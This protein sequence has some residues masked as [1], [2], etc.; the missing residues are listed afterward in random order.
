M[1]TTYSSNIL[2]CE[3]EKG[4]K[5]PKTPKDLYESHNGLKTNGKTITIL[6]THYD[7]HSDIDKVTYMYFQ[8]YPTRFISL[9]ECIIH[10][11][12]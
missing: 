8:V 4:R 2:A 5:S 11:T 12:N 10:N 9:H 1:H 7:Q 6:Q 3:W